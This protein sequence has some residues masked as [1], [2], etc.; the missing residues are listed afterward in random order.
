LEFRTNLLEN[1]KAHFFAWRILR[2]P[3]RMRL[4][5]CRPSRKHH[6]RFAPFRAR[7]AETTIARENAVVTYILPSDKDT[8]VEGYASGAHGSSIS[9]FP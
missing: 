4:S 5:L 1:D 2:E 9:L 8:V 3:G 6:R 7:P